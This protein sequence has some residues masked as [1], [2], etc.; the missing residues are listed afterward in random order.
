MVS[1]NILDNGLGTDAAQ[2]LTAI[3][4]DHSTLKSL[5]G[6][7]ANETELDMNGKK[8]GSE[9]AILL[10]PEIV[11]NGAMKTVTIN[12]FALPIQDIKTKSQL[13]FAGKGLKV[14]DA[15]IIAALIPLN[16][17]IFTVTV[18]LLL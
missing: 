3:L 5:C 17:S 12:K 1:V 16:V 4:K 13:H 10:A 9:G 18:V 2:K 6:N 14:E 7:K 11:A 8:I 15:I